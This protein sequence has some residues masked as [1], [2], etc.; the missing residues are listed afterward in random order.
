MQQLLGSIEDSIKHKNWLSAIYIAITLPDICA[1]AENSVKGNGL[2]YKDWFNRYLKKKYD[3]ANFYEYAEAYHPS[4]LSY[5]PQE[6]LDDYKKTPTQVKFTAEY[7]WA[8]RNAILHEGVDESNLKNFRL[9]VPDDRGN[10][11]HLTHDSARKFVQIDVSILCLDMI[12]AVESWIA[13]MASK[14]DVI[15]KLNNMIR[16]RDQRFI[17]D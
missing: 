4:R 1:A 10:V 17:F 15:A 13:D 6:V 3:S 16:I 12:E 11:H 2:R 14:P 8:L 7:C 9:T 5:L